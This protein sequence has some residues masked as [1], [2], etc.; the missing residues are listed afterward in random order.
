MSEW[1][2]VKLSDVC[3]FQNG[4]AFKSSQFCDNGK[5][6]IIKIKELKNGEITFFNDTA[7]IINGAEYKKYE[8]CNGDVLFALTGD[9]VSKSNPLSWVGRVSRYKGKEK[10]LLNQRVCIAKPSN[11]ELDKDFLFYY[12]RTFE[13]YFRLAS[14]AT[15]SANQ[16]NISTKTL[17]AEVFQ[18][19]PLPEQRT[20]TATLS[21][22]DNKIAN[23]NAINQRLEQMAQAI[24]KSW[25]VDFEPWGGVMPEDWMEVEFSSFLIPRVEKSN[26]PTIPL[27]S[28]TDTGIYLRSEKFNKKLSRKDTKNKI[29]YETD[30]IFGMSRE[31]LN[32]GVMRS[33]I[34]CVSAA[35]NIY[36]VDSSINSRYLESFIQAHIVYF[37]DL[38]RPA[39]RE[40]QGLD[41]GALMAKSIYLPPQEVLRHYYEIDDVISAQIKEYENETTNLS[42]IR[43]ALLP[44]MMSGEI[45]ISDLFEAK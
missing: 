20:I 24:F 41:K 27:F 28:V 12:F 29:A 45:S 10:C 17:G 31:I 37:R 39:T 23:N 34:G 19:P 33:P 11:G 22:L 18:L 36:A 42:E 13:N 14:K 15:G 1:R 21:A 26:D 32:W 35:Y 3:K 16:A 8:V 44:R 2:N 5:Y 7:T 6:K 38:I 30:L 9:P 43:D 4:F 25:F 40:G